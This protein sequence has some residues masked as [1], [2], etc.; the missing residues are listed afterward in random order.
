MDFAMPYFIQVMKEY[1]TK[2]DKLDASESLRKE[3]EQA[4][5]TQPIVYGNLA[6]FLTLQKS[7]RQTFSFF[8]D[9]T[10]KQK[11]SKFLK[12]ERLTEFR[13]NSTIFF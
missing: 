1:L 5:E 3:E 10:S 8:R 11:Y 4:T 9:P 13:N 6:L 12:C 7:S 2:V